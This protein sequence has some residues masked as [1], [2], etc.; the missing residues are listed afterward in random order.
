M[1]SLLKHRY[2]VE[3]K[4]DKEAKDCNARKLCFN[5]TLSWA[6]AIAVRVARL[7]RKIEDF[8]H[9]SPI[10]INLS[11]SFYTIES[12]E[13]RTR[14]DAECLKLTPLNLRTRLRSAETIASG[15]EEDDGKSEKRKTEDAKILFRL[16]IKPGVNAKLYSCMFFTAFS[17]KNS[18]QRVAGK[19]A[20]K[21]TRL[22][23]EDNHGDTSCSRKLLGKLSI[24]E[25][26]SRLMF[27]PEKGAK[28]LHINQS[29]A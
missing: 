14:N 29:Y 2:N 3:S 28:K 6:A 12:N 11:F 24:P 16:I 27:S 25:T 26:L 13:C 4:P 5:S 19:I 17:T 15:S 10:K 1:E 8:I 7:E 22:I 23:D 20:E 18:K 21:V 9:N